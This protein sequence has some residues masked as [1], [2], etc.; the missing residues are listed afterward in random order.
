MDQHPER[1]IHILEAYF[2][3]L[4]GQAFNMTND[5]SRASVLEF[6]TGWGYTPPPPARLLGQAGAPAGAVLEEVARVAG[7]AS[8]F[9]A[10]PFSGAR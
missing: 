1:N 6:F 7:A 8:R 10:P 9:A 5:Y 4:Y 2:G 3:G